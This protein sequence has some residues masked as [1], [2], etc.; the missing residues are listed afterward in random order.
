M[1]IES[2]ELLALRDLREIN[3][4]IKDLENQQSVVSKKFKLGIRLLQR[5]ASMT[6][7]HL[8]DGCVMQGCESWNVRHEKLKNLID[9]PNL[10]N[11][12]DDTTV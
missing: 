4:A 9:D 3:L 10:E 2:N 11:I 8:D 5:E 1:S 7:G 6:E 12:P